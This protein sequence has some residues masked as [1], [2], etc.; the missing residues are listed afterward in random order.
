MIFKMYQHQN[1]FTKTWKASYFQGVQKQELNQRTRFS[2]H[3]YV[4][5]MKSFPLQNLLPSLLVILIVNLNDVS[6]VFTC[7][8]IVFPPP[9]KN[10]NLK[11]IYNWVI[12]S[13]S[14]FYLM[15]FWIKRFK[16]LCKDRARTVTAGS[17][18]KHLENRFIFCVNA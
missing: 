12:P 17:S 1:I 5:C 7:Y 2:F 10:K 8:V 14:S 6:H 15:G 11:T 18:L 9:P 13:L 4:H 3:M 16:G